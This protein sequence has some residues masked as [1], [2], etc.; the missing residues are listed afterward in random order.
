MKM[1]HN[2]PIKYPGEQFFLILCIFNF[3]F[4]FESIILVTSVRKLNATMLM[5]S[6]IVGIPIPP[7]KGWIFVNFPDYLKKFPR[8]QSIGVK[9]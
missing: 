2:L 8:L 4:S 1:Q 3:T 6:C 7:F 5:W 9:I